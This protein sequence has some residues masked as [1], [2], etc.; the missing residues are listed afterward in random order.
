[1]T[2]IRAMGVTI[3][4]GLDREIC[5]CAMVAN[6]QIYSSTLGKYSYEYIGNLIEYSNRIWMHMCRNFTDYV[7]Y[8]FCLPSVYP[9]IQ[10]FN[11]DDVNAHLISTFHNIG[12]GNEIMQLSCNE[13]HTMDVQK[14]FTLACLQG[15]LLSY[16]YIYYP[17]NA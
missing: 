14:Q 10:I 6:I 3:A 4:S 9:D 7:E 8:M 2:D 1:M 5:S 11:I 16:N 12:Q 13:N 17:L 15:K